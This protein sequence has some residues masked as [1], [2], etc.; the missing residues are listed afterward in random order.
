ML[1]IDQ[2]FR[3]KQ[4]GIVATVFFED[5]TPEETYKLGDVVTD[6]SGSI[7][8]IVGVEHIRHGCFGPPKPFNEMPL[9]LCLKPIAPTPDDATPMGALRKPIIVSGS[10][11][12][13]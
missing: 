6:T 2:V 9:G 7:F 13:E 3:I 4:R 11:L 8:K 5:M 1:R 10:Y 12:P